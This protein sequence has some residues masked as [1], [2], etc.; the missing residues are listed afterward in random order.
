MAMKVARW[1]IYPLSADTNKRIAE[2]LDPE[3]SMTKILCADRKWR[4]VWECDREL[5]DMLRNSRE[6]SGFEFKVYKQ[7]GNGSIV[8]DMGKSKVTGKALT[9][10]LLKTRRRPVTTA[11]K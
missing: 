1:Y 11:S 4:P 6:G 7:M 8:R 10:K 3:R 5:V 9:Q 2:M